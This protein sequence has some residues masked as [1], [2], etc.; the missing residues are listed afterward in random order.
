MNLAT[1]QA[2]TGDALGDVLSDIDNLVGSAFA[3]V[4]TGGG[5]ANVLTGGLGADKLTGGGGLD[6]F[7]FN[8]VAEGKD[9]ITD[10]E[11]GTDLISIQIRLRHCFRRRAGDRRCQ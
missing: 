5:N 11:I 2:G 1:V 10:F 9:T 6:T 4:L 8:N 3:D 7:V